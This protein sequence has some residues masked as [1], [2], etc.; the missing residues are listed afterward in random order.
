MK[1]YVILVATEDSAVEAAVRLLGTTDDCEFQCVKTTRDAVSMLMDG[2]LNQNLAIVDL[3]LH[4]GGRSLLS[5]AGGALPVIAITA[6][7]NP[8]LASMQRHHRIGATLTKPISPEKL[9]D[10]FEHVR[11]DAFAEDWREG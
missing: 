4:E 9:R 10:A 6:K 1:H 2:S 3:D 7:T 8:W 11:R 5:T